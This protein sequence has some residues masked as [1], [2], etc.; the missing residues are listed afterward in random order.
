MPP[1]KKLTWSIQHEE[2]YNAI[3]NYLKNSLGLNINKESY[4]ESITP[5][6]IYITANPKWSDSTKE[7][8]YL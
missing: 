4:I 7:T 8:I 2:R 3:F 5:T 6:N 1:T